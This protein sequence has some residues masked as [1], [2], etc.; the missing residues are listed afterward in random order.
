MPFS[1]Q[2]A[3]FLARAA[4]RS[5]ALF[6]ALATACFVSAKAV[7]CAHAFISIFTDAGRPDERFLILRRSSADLAPAVDLRDDRALDLSRR[8]RRWYKFHREFLSFQTQALKERQTAV[9]AQFCV[10]RLTPSRHAFDPCVLP[11]I[12]QTGTPGCD[13]G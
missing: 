8:D 9:T 13:S 6:V 12:I 4:A 10:H 1:R 7:T 3:C 11:Q 5:S 2:I